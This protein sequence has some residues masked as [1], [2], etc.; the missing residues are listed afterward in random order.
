[1]VHKN[2]ATKETIMDDLVMSVELAAKLNASFR[3]AGWTLDDVK[4]LSDVDKAQLVLDVVRDE[5][6]LQFRHLLHFMGKTTVA[7]CNRDDVKEKVQDTSLFLPGAFMWM[8]DN[9]DGW[10]SEEISE[11]VP[12]VIYSF[13]KQG[14]LARIFESVDLNVKKLVLT[15]VQI[16][17]FCIQHR[18]WLRSDGKGNFF[19]TKQ[20]EKLNVIKIVLGDDGLL[21]Y[22][23]YDYTNT[24]VWKADGER[25]IIPQV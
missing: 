9:R 17:G 3:R 20:G 12:V 5:A 6:D 13:S 16:A 2:F 21:G 10:N 4:A 25:F 23:F 8:L 14:R 15:P 18:G 7:A 11:Q 24:F 22:T 1:M 19:L